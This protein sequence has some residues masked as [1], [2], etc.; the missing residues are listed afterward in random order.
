[1][2]KATRLTACVILALSYLAAAP[3]SQ[4]PDVKADVEKA[5]AAFAAA[6]AK[7][8]A[9][10]LA[11]MYS[12]DAQAF[13]PNSDVLGTREAIRKLWQGAMDGGVKSVS[14]QTTEV[15]AHGAD[16]AHEVGTYAMMAAGGTVV[17]RGKYLV[18]WKREKGTWKLHRD[19]WNTS[20]P[21]A[22]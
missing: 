3:A 11:S 13:P 2:S 21:A 12:S 10:A 4:R 14:L 19:I 22:K 5:N 6:F 17:D 20:L 18:I 15:E 9:A 1:M 7:G 16:V 8:D